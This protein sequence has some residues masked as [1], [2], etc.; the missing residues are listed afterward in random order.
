MH[1]GCFVNQVDISWP[2]SARHRFLQHSQ[3]APGIFLGIFTDLLHV[4][5]YVGHFC[6]TIPSWFQELLIQPHSIQILALLS[7]LGYAT[8]AESLENHVMQIRTGEGK[9]IALGGGAALL[10]L[11]GFRVRCVCYSEYLSQRDYRAFSALFEALSVQ[12]SVTYST[13]TQYS[14]STQSLAVKC[15]QLRCAGWLSKSP[16]EA[17]NCNEIFNHGHSYQSLAFEV[18]IE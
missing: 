14:N 10:A 1:V 7:L 15:C 4:C 18:K 16:S 8:K 13:V 5:Q 6:E 9:S 12:N 3:P 2:C 11:L 17:L